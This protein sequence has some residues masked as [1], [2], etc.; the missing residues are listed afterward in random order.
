[1]V[2][3]PFAG[4]LTARYGC[5]LVIVWSTIALSVLL[6]LLSNIAWLAGSLVW[7][8]MSVHFLSPWVAWYFFFFS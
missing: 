2:A 7:S 3:M 4:H 5:R 1:M 6:T 8:P